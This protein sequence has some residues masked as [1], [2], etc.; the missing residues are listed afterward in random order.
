MKRRMPVFLFIV[1]LLGLLFLA[2]FAIKTRYGTK[3]DGGQ[4]EEGV[5]QE[6]E[7]PVMD[8]E[9]TIRAFADLVYT[10]DTSERRFY[11]GTETYMTKAAYEKMVPMQSG[12]SD[13]ETC[14][15]SSELLDITTYYR[16]EDEKNLTVF[17]EVWY[18][19]SSAGEFR[20]RQLIKMQLTMEEKWVINDY[21]V[22]DIME[23]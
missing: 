11:E 10:Y 19:L 12:K 8:A 2:V 4:K 22:L 23:E 7:N 3:E 13:M 20:C 9:D 14:S 6:E 5:L 15:M 21:T 17:A 18:R 1:I 16:T